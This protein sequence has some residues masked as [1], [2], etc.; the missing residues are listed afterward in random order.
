M[1]LVKIGD[2]ENLA[3]P[4]I[5]K[6]C[7]ILVGKVLR[8]IYQYSKKL[9]KFKNFKLFRATGPVFGT[10]RPKDSVSGQGRW[11]GCHRR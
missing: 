5:C 6:S 2:R 7:I 11:G 8:K 3:I 4:P 1:S 9:A 10:A